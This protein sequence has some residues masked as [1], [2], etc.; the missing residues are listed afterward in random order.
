MSWEHLSHPKS[1]PV[2]W[3][4]PERCQ[5]PDPNLDDSVLNF[6][7]LGSNNRLGVLPLECQESTSGL[8]P[9]KFL[10]LPIPRLGYQS[11]LLSHTSPN[12]V[13]KLQMLPSTVGKI[14]RCELFPK[15]AEGPSQG[16][17][18]QPLQVP[19]GPSNRQWSQPEEGVSRA[20]K[21]P[22]SP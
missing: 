4:L 13:G 21:S 9:N 6:R 19:P 20:R 22:N 5:F 14:P 17:K 15:A 8:N 18:A 10:Y 3:G 1:I 11:S 12:K 2:P 16:K 7:V